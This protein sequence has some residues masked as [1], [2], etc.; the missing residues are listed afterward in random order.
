MGL[1]GERTIK[2][3]NNE[4]ERGNKEREMRDEAE[5]KTNIR[6]ITYD[7]HNQYHHGY[8]PAQT[9]DEER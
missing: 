9:R 1:W 3:E 6:K 7:P 8:Q 4:L 2:K 5:G